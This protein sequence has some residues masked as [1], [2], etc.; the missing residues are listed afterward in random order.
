MLVDRIGV[1]AAGEQLFGTQVYQ[2][3]D[4]ITGKPGKYKYFPIKDEKNVDILRKQA[5]MIP[6]KQYLSTFGIDYK[7]VQ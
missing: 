2:E 4:S 3:K 5:G 1:Q 7:P 6:L